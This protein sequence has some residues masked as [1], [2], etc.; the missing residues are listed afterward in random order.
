MTHTS[1]ADPRRSQ[2]YQTYVLVAAGLALAA[3]IYWNRASGPVDMPS[4][5]SVASVFGTASQRAEA[6]AAGARAGAAVQALPAA[7]FVQKAALD[8]MFE[9]EAG[10]IARGKTDPGA[11]DFADQMIIAH[12][13]IAAELRGLQES[14]KLGG[15]LPTELDAEQRAKLD[16]LRALDGAAFRDAYVR[17]QRDAHRDAV[18]MFQAYARAGDDPE[19]RQWAESTLPTLKQ[20]LDMA[21]ALN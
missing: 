19:L 8:Q 6:G 11:L 3:F 4:M 13:A 12:R 18:A 20:H 1:K 16:E 5:G 9:I 10:R 17:M 2:G 21:R 14:G 7:A 15:P